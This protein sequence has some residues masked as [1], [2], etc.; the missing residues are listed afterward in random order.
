MLRSGCRNDALSRTAHEYPD[1]AVNRPE[2]PHQRSRSPETER[3]RR[4]LATHRAPDVGAA[5]GHRGGR[6]RRAGVDPGQGVGAPARRAGHRQRHR[7]GR[8]GGHHPLRLDD[9]RGGCGHRLLHRD[10]PVLG[11]PGGP[12]GRGGAA[13]SAV[14][15]P[16][17]LA[18]RLPRRPADRP[19][20]EPGQQRPP[21]DPERGGPGAAHH[22]QPDHGHGGA[23]HL[24]EHGPGAHRARPRVAAR[25][26]RP[27]QALRLAA[28]TGHDRRPAGV[29][30]A[31]GG[32][33]GDRGGDP[34]REG[35]RR[36]GHP[37]GAARRRG[38]R[39]LR[40]LHAGG[41]HPVVVL[42]GARAAAQ[43]RAD[44]GPRSTAA[45]R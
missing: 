39:P 8:R 1:P 36:R 31:V 29:G 20:H 3:R 24:G 41:V 26:Q 14:R 30:R 22:R 4:W 37:G 45:T 6:R 38:R 18:L 16:P 19:A 7:A 40:R 15:P 5:R 9:R 33:G 21:A 44:H 13:R 27:G 42:A 11:V 25:H 23:D 28:P 17:A 12:Q 43:R 32:G 2:A 35:L 34:G 10:P